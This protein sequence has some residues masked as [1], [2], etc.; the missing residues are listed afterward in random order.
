MNL[1][2]SVFGVLSISFLWFPSLAYGDDIYWKSGNVWKNVKVLEYKDGK[3]KVKRAEDTQWW[4]A[5]DRI[6]FK[7]IEGKEIVSESAATLEGKS[8]DLSKKEQ[9]IEGRETQPATQP[10]VQQIPGQKKASGTAQVEK[11]E[12]TV[13]VTNT[14]K[15]YHRGN[16]RHLLKSKIL[17]SKKEAI[18]DG[19]TPCSVCKP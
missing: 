16:C 18:A 6:V 3:I 10:A 1:L 7:E 11:K 8:V 15:K 14:G 5:F 2:I 12:E 9:E 17:I 13:Y 4:K 19:Y